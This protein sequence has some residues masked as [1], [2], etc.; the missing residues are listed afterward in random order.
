MKPFSTKIK[1][2][3]SE[4]SCLRKRAKSF[5]ARLA[6][7]TK[8]YNDLAFQQVVKNMRTPARLFVRMQLQCM[9]KPKGRRFTLEEKIL[10]LSLY[11][12][13]PKSYSLL[14]KYFTLPS[15][16][17]MKRLLSNIKLCPGINPILFKKIKETV[18]QKEIPD[19]LCMQSYI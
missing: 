15:S 12:K 13:S 6:N 17:A 2:L 1:H 4:I 18:L 5:K 10:A 19:R 8:L 3:Q 9:K 14:Y 11:K 16:K 7:A